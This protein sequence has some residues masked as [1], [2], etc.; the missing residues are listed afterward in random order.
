MG[1]CPKKNEAFITA[2]TVQFN[3]CAGDFKKKG[4]AYHGSLHVM[5]NI[6]GNDFL[7]NNVREK[8]GAYGC[9]CGFGLNGNGYLTSYRDPKLSE[10]Y[11]I[12]EKAA[13]Y[14]R[15]LKLDER[16]LTKYII[17]AIGRLDTPMT[18]SMKG[19]RSLAAY[20]VGRSWEEMQ[21]NRDELLGTT[22][23]QLQK[24]ADVVEAI[25]EA[26]CFCV[27]G[28]ESRIMQ[29]QERFEHISQLLR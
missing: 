29:A 10:T 16:E 1:V 11:E 28:S 22:V 9:M 27:V 8:G 14:M 26:D 15:H 13:D 23:E 24:L 4:L 17:G 5:R 3:A 20:L 6:L 12:Y 25:V 21:K 7:W 18:V 19:T 2:G